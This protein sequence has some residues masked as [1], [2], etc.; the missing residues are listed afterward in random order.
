MDLDEPSDYQATPRR[1]FTCTVSGDTVIAGNVMW[2]EENSIQIS[3]ETREEIYNWESEGKTVVCIGINNVLYGII[4]LA[5]TLKPESE[6][7]IKELRKKGVE[8]W[9]LSGDKQIT[10]NYIASQLGV[11]NAIGQSLPNEKANKIRELKG[12]GKIVTMIGDGINDSIAISAAN[13]GMAIDSGSDIALE[14]SDIVLMKSN[15]KDVL[16]GLDLSQTTYR[17]IKINFVLAFLY[18]MIGIPLAAGFFI[19]YSI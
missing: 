13:I 7:V 1:G 10:T 11:K 3:I 9:I 6:F 17:R 2:M 8:V 14:T 16:I 15:I 18:N 4:G 19:L 12:Y 5:D